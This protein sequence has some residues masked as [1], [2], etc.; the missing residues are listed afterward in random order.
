[1]LFFVLVIGVYVYKMWS[2]EKYNTPNGR[3]N[4]FK[5]ANLPPEQYAL[6]VACCLNIAIFDWKSEC[7]TLI[8]AS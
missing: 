6:N 8:V 7:A 4:Y 2:K 3:D 5:L 1:M